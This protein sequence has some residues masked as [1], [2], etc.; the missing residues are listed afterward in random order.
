MTASSDF[1]KQQRTKERKTRSMEPMIGS[2]EFMETARLQQLRGLVDGGQLPAAAA[3]RYCEHRHATLL[4]S[5][6]LLKYIAITFDFVAVGPSAQPRPRESGRGSLSRHSEPLAPRPPPQPHASGALRQRST[7]RPS[8]MLGNHA[9][10]R[11]LIC[12]ACP[13]QRCEIARIARLQV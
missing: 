10:D 4:Q 5:M 6:R 3:A 1:Y 12:A 9:H 11:L 13:Q 8:D 7:A 2:W